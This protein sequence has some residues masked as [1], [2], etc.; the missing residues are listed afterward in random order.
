M[1][2]ILAV[3]DSASMRQMLSH[4]LRTAGFEVLVAGD[5][6]DALAQAARA[7][8]EP[9]WQLPMYPD[10][11]EQ[12]KSEVD[13]LAARD[14]IRAHANECG[15]RIAGELEYARSGRVTLTDTT[16]RGRLNK[17]EDK[18]LHR[19]LLLHLGRIHGNVAGTPVDLTA[20]LPDDFATVVKRLGKSA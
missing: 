20:P 12:I 15:L 17:G 10:Y 4:T 1:Q 14:Q 13:A 18:P 16:R 3:D 6:V 5:G 19:C 11:D 8:G 7:V 2:T 9:V